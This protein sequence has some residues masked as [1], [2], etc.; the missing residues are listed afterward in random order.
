M[1]Q[2]SSLYL[3][4]RECERSLEFSNWSLSMQ[5]QLRIAGSCVDTWVRNTWIFSGLQ[6]DLQDAAVHGKVK[7]A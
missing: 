6:T 5:R 4:F 2:S 1:Q 7:F 3:F